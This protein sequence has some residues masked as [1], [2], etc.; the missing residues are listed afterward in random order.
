M[1]LATVFVDA[2]VRVLAP[3]LLV[4]VFLSVSFGVIIGAI[5]GL[6]PAIG[7]VLLF[8]LTISLDPLPAVAL[9]A[10]IYPAGVYGGSITAVL[11]NTPGDPSSTVTTFDGYPMTKQG[12]GTKALGITLVASV[13]GGF[14]SGLALLLL[15]PPFA[16][17][18]LE[19]T[20]DIIFAIGLFG[21]VIL[22]LVSRGSLLKGLVASVFGLLLS[23][24]G[25]SPYRGVERFTFGV[26]YLSDGIAI[27]PLIVGLFAISEAIMLVYQGGTI[28][29]DGETGAPQTTRLRFS[30]L[31]SGMMSTVAR[32]LTVLRSSIIGIVI[33]I[34]P[35]SGSIVANF[36]SY[37]VGQAF[38]KAGDTFGTGSIE[39][40]ISA[41]SSNNAATAATL[42]PTLVLGI[43]GGIAAA[44]LLGVLQLKNVRV[45][46][47]LFAE[48]PELA[49]AI[50]LSL[51]VANVFI[52]I[53]GAVV[54]GFIQRIVTL[55]VEIVA[56]TVFIL[57]I[58]GGFA[59]NFQTADA[60]AVIGF[61]VIGFVLRKLGYS[62]IAIVFGFILGPIL[63]NNY[64]RAVQTAGNDPLAA[65]ASPIPIAIGGVALVLLVYQLFEE[66]TELRERVGGSQ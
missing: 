39:G 23:I 18:A 49:Y 8:P 64:L 7:M 41:E 37:Y 48:T 15:A 43:P 28:E 19:I 26:D 10:A 53:V 47:L 33:G 12:D 29:E 52:L 9:L 32:P 56:P 3:D 22:V 5:P 58:L 11:I 46:P 61:G 57:A 38:S 50:I 21:I 35:G 6:G 27:V 25:F 34:V 24:V 66:A 44:I 59:Y 45:G 42:I 2:L 55:P 51:L 54:S 31:Y 14:L 40:L 63:E 30:D 62:I 4:L 16:R 1:V 36:V 13:I 60:I 17:I 20:P 65:F